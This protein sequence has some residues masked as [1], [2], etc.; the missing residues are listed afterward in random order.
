M[1]QS[2]LIF[3]NAAAG[4]SSDLL[5]SLG[6]DV[7]LLILQTIAFLLLL[8]IL[9]KFVYPVLSKSLEK[10]EQT[11]NSAAKA[12]VEAQKEAD[13]SRDKVAKLLKQ[14]KAE[15]SAIVATAKAEADE[16]VSLATEKSRATAD[17]MIEEAKKSIDKEVLSAK[18]ALHNETI[19]LVAQATEKVVAG[20]MTG[21]IDK[22]I[23][24][25]AVKQ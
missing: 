10:R 18:K 13:E 21:S 16:M 9:K 1:S 5:G 23:I 22:K 6:I 7:K 20:Q 25:S 2:L 11:I 15:A 17:H 24:E 3:A 19:E 12:A 14:A 8:W 4:E